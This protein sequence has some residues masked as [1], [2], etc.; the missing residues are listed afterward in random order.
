MTDIHGLQHEHLQTLQERYTRVLQQQGYGALLISS[1]AAPMRYGD[2]QSHHHQGYGPFLHWTGLAGVE[3]SWLL[4][5]AGQPPRLWL[6]TPVDFWHASPELPDEPWTDVIRVQ[7]REARNA[8]LGSLPDK[9]AVIGDPAL[10]DG[11]PGSHNPAGLIEALDQQ[12]IIKTPY[13]VHCIEHANAIA[14]KGH[15]AARDAFLRGASELGGTSEFEINLAYQRATGQREAQAPYHSIIGLN[16]HA[17]TLH[18]QHYAADRPDPARS[19]LIDAGYRY[20]GYCSD[21]TRTTAAPGE[22]R[23]AALIS[24]L[25]RL[26]K[27]L[28]NAVAPG[29]DYPQLHQTAHYGIAALLTAIDLVTDLDEKTMVEQG[30]TRAFYPHGLG[31]LLGIQVHDVAGKPRPS[32]E[33]APALRLTHRLEPGMVLTIEPGLYFIPSL[34]KP[35]LDSDLGRHLNRPLIDELMGCGGIRIEDNVLVTED[36]ARNLTRPYLP[37]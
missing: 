9:L 36:G 5:S 21:I 37:D 11:I 13:E 24:G 2:D 10:L 23:F 25:E 34:L 18:Y 19:L 3:H 6:H 20:R 8:P 31:H 7:R 30:I 26:Q 33:H 17:G 14:A 12:R 27:R 15:H 16:A 29:V 1:G 4:I 28:C 35:I 32:P 22:M